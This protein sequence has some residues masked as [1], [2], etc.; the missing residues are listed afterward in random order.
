MGIPGPAKSESVDVIERFIMDNLPVGGTAFDVGANQGLYTEVMLRNGSHVFAFEPNPNAAASLRK[1]LHAVNIDVV[2]MVIGDTQGEVV[3]YLDERPDMGGC[4]SSMYILNGLELQTRKIYVSCT[5][6][7]AFSS[8]R[9]VVPNLIKIDVEG[10]E[11]HVIAGA[12]TIIEKYKPILIFEFWESWWDLGIR[13]VFE[14]LDQ[15]YDL[16]VLQT[17]EEAFTLYHTLAS[18]GRL[19]SSTKTVDVGCKPRKLT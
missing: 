16:F 8:Q 15:Y 18:Q 2:E 9:S 4:A 13:D 12:K 17:G 14:Y 3:F 6:L 11:P 19:P 5:T 7:D 1:R 10:H